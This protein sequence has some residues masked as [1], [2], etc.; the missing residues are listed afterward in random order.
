MVVGRKERE[1]RLLKRS[2]DFAIP[3]T[4]TDGSK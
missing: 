4:Y 1:A 2:Q 3:T